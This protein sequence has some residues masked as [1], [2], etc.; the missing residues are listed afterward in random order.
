VPTTWVRFNGTIH[1]IMRLNALRD[2]EST[3]AALSLAAW[4]LRGAFDADSATT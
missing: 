2:S 1:E 4:A 3:R